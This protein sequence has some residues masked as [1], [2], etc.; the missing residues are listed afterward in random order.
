MFVMLARGIPVRARLAAL[1]VFTLLA[2]GAA[3][4]DIA[5]DAGTSRARLYERAYWELPDAWRTDRVIGVREVPDHAMDRLVAADDPRGSRYDQDSI[6]DAF[7][8]AG[9]RNGRWWAEITLRESLPPA[10]A[11]VVFLHEY[12]HFVWHELLSSRDRAAYRRVWERSRREGSLVTRYAA[13]SPEEGF[14]DS[15]AYFVLRPSTLRRRDPR[16]LR[17]LDD[18][19]AR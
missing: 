9:R 15:A 1:A 7:Y 5:V 14:A 2:S 18:L 16:S 12:A 8:E 19:L 10:E 17:F 4:A 13:D 11:E 6:V 3:C